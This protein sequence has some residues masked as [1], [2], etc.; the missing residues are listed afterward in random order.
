MGKYDAI[1]NLPHHVSEK[2][3]RMSMSGRAAQFAPFAALAGFEETVAEAARRTDA[4]PELDEDQRLLIDETL[5]EISERIDEAPV[6]RAEYF[7]PDK[8]KSGG[9]Y[10]AVTGAVKKLDGAKRELVLSDGGSVPIDGLC[11]LELLSGNEE[12]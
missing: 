1:I 12:A 11:R 6:V 2:R 8:R 5:R 9:A 7:L 3:P 4:E 10:V